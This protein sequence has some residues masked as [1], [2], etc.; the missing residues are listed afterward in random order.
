[1]KK[2]L[3]LVMGDNICQGAMR[4]FILFFL[5]GCYIVS[6]NPHYH[7]PDQTFQ[8]LPLITIISAVI[9]LNILISLADDMSRH[10]SKGTFENVPQMIS[11]SFFNNNSQK[12]WFDILSYSIV[13]AI[14]LPTFSCD[15]S[16]TVKALSELTDYEKAF[17]YWDFIAILISLFLSV[18]YYV[19]VF[20][21]NFDFI[22]YKDKNGKSCNNAWMLIIALLILSSGVSLFASMWLLLK[23]HDYYRMLIGLIIAGGCFLVTDIIYITRANVKLRFLNGNHSD[24]FKTVKQKIKEF[25]FSLT[26]GNIPATIGFLVL[27]AVYSQFR[28]TESV[29]YIE[30]FVA[31]GAAMHIVFGNIIV[32]IGLGGEQ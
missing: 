6:D 1:M 14:F 8:L 10:F 21:R 9:I 32:G 23:F 31:G 16:R 7:N 24:E 26:L 22:H 13:L 4:I 2:F 25:K 18:L 15:W 12:I 5:L 27:F 17:L 20:L 11:K 30:G 19:D 28:E 29:K 3:L